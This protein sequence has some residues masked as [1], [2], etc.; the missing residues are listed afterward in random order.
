M[1]NN[2]TRMNELF[3][4][5]VKPFWLFLFLIATCILCPCRHQSFLLTNS[6]FLYRL[7]VSRDRG[8]YLRV[9][10]SLF[11]DRFVRRGNFPRTTCVEHCFS[12]FPLCYLFC[13]RSQAGAG[14]NELPLNSPWVDQALEATADPSH[15]TG[16]LNLELNS[17]RII[18]SQIQRSQYHHCN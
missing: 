8:V 17:G 14:R 6:L 11:P 9:I 10:V 5:A 4:I 7:F 13:T 15:E 16:S 12:T 3:A 1:A 18:V 2:S